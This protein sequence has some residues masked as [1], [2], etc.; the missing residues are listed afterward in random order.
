[1]RPP[2]RSRRPA[3]AASP[4]SNEPRRV[5]VPRRPSAGCLAQPGLFCS[6]GRHRPAQELPLPGC[7]RS[8]ERAL[9]RPPGGRASAPET[10]FCLAPRL[11]ETTRKKAARKRWLTGF[12]FLSWTADS[13]AV[14]RCTA[15]CTASVPDGSL[16]SLGKAFLP[17]I[18][19]GSES[20]QVK[21]C[22]S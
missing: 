6:H 17:E 10:L 8:F 12:W 5:Q 15:L 7:W 16:F 18:L 1:M 4:A 2:V 11:M 19:P 14:S 21:R 9:S 3:R 20:S 22:R 13:L